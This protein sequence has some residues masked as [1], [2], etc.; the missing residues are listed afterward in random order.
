MRSWSDLQNL[1]LYTLEVHITRNM[2]PHAM[3]EF[4]TRWQCGNLFDLGF[5]LIFYTQM[6]FLVLSAVIFC[7]V[8][9]SG[10]I[11]LVTMWLHCCA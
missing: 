11:R 8:V 10:W 4:V 2:Y 6:V 3:K 9:F 1:K 7:F 5:V